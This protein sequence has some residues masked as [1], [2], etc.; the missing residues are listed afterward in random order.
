MLK[1]KLKVLDGEFTIYRF[2]PAAAI[3]EGVLKS[4]IFWIART[5][6]EL[7]VV[8]DSKVALAGEDSRPGWACVKVRGPI[9][10]SQT[11]ILAGISAVLA[12]AEIS[13]FAVS[14]YDTDYV[15]VPAAELDQAAAALA[16]SGYDIT[17]PRIIRPT[18]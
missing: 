11:G 13:I 8:C 15:L 6:E 1:P 4:A 5:D 16:A 17:G 18:T 3:P 9:D 12:A 14:T 10:F 7:S 2:S